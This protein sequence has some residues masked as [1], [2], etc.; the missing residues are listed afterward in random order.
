MSMKLTAAALSLLMPLLAAAHGTAQAPDKAKPPVLDKKT[1][2]AT[3]VAPEYVQLAKNVEVIPNIESA[4]KTSGV[5]THEGLFGPLLFAERTRAFFLELKPGMYLEEHPHDLGSIVY[6]VRGKWVLVSEGKRQVME[7][8]SLFR[9]GD[10]MPTGWEAPFADG[11]LV[12]IFK[13]MPQKQTYDS[14]NKGLTKV[15][16][17]IEA[18]H[19]KGTPFYFSELKPDH[20]AVVFARSVNPDFDAVLKNTR[21]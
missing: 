5:L 20:P 4:V 17:E 15:Q 2:P 12:L 14:F 10:K 8:G 6:T 11:A 3:A 7:T 9:F 16:G 18:Q 19:K 1:V 21:K 13:H